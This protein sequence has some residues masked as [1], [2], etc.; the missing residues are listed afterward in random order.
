MCNSRRAPI[1][2]GVKR[3]KVKANLGKFELVSWC[4]GVLF[5]NLGQVYAAKFH[6]VFKPIF[7]SVLEATVYPLP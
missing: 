3:S 7:L 1:D 2:I 4:P 5:V 6:S